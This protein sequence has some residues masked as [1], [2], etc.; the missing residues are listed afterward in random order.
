VAKHDG[1]SFRHAFE[2]LNHGGAAAFES[3]PQLQSRSSVPRLPSPLDLKVDDMVLLKQVAGYYHVSADGQ[4]VPGR[5]DSKCTT[6]R[7]A[8]KPVPFRAGFHEPTQ[9]GANTFD[10]RTLRAG[11][12]R[13]A[14]RP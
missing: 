12:V 6:L 3:H 5:V 8:G 9:N 11:V 14:D 1:V 2:L 7:W 10:S 4:S 13:A